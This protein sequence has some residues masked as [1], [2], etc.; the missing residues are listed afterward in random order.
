MRK[1]GAAAVLKDTR[2]PELLQAIK[3]AAAGQMQFSSSALTP[4]VRKTIQ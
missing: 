1:T 3:A 4:L 2:G